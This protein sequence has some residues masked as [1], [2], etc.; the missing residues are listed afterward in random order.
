MHRSRIIQRSLSFGSQFSRRFPKFPS[1]QSPNQTAPFG[2][3]G[4]ANPGTSAGGSILRAEPQSTSASHHSQTQQNKHSPEYTSNA[5]PSE[6][7]VPLR[8][9]AHPSPS[10]FAKEEEEASSP[11]PPRARYPRGDVRGGMIVPELSR[12][13][14]RPGA[15]ADECAPLNRRKSRIVLR[16]EPH[17]ASRTEAKNYHPFSTF[18]SKFVYT[19]LDPF[20]PLPLPLPSLPGPF[21]PSSPFPANLP[22][23]PPFPFPPAFSLPPLSPSLSSSPSPLPPPSL[24]LHPFPPPSLLSFPNLSPSRLPPPFPL[25]PSPPFPSSHTSSPPLPHPFFLPPLPS[26]TPFPSCSLPFPLLLLPFPP[27]SRFPPLSLLPLPLSPLN[28][29]S[30][31]AFWSSISPRARHAFQRAAVVPPPPSPPSAWRE[32]RP[33]IQ[34]PPPSAS[35]RPSSRPSVALVGIAYSSVLSLPFILFFILLFL[36]LCLLYMSPTAGMLSTKLRTQLLL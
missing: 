20:S 21:S 17:T 2:F 24:P 18:S 15:I 36:F 23:P 9:G 25:P 10:P 35:R 31:R 16:T 29:N 1:P 6:G 28:S 14:T 5:D 34:S 13:V 11:P 27:S 22:F 8:N 32:G 19:S 4:S 30:S 3:P 12:L 7:N 33:C 26:S